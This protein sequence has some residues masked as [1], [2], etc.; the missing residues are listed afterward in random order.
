[1][2][3]RNGFSRGDPKTT[4]WPPSGAQTWDIFNRNLYISGETNSMQSGLFDS[5]SMLGASGDQFRTGARV[6]RNFFYQGSVG[7]GAQ[8]GYADSEGATGTIVDNVLQKF[9]GSGTDENRGQPGWGFILGGGAYSVEVARNIVSGA[10]Y[11]SDI[12]GI[13]LMPLFQDCERPFLYATR[14]NNVHDNIFDTGAADAAIS[15]TDGTQA[16][17]CYNWS[18]RG[19]KNNTVADNI[20]LNAKGKE[21]E[22]VPMGTAFGTTS[23]TAF[24]RNKLFADR[25][26]AAAALG[27]IGADRTLKT[28]MQ[29]R[30]VTVTS[31]DGFPEYFR[32][33]TQ[34]RRGRWVADWT[35]TPLV[36]HYRTGFAM[37]ALPA[38]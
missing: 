18:W 12:S 2:L 31:A 37:T 3:L 23:D 21:S 38:R 26:A 15:T 11:G 1:M 35:S 30:G 27:W 13:Q 24:S 36:N 34:Q 19:V 25:T 5:V 22:Y 10:Q 32:A 33:A 16:S 14:S 8:G 6:E 28:Y 29:S 9:M 20:L 17:S 7:V 4:A